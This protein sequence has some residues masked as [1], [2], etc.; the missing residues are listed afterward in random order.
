MA[1]TAGGESGSGQVH[2]GDTEATCEAP[3]PSTPG[4]G[5]G[6]ALS[7]ECYRHVH[8]ICYCVA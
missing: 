1:V 6:K 5:G 3:T 7:I 4:W 2:F 8:S